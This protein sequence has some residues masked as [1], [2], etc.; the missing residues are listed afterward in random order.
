MFWYTPAL[1]LL[2][3]VILLRS[4]TNKC[5]VSVVQNDEWREEMEERKR[6]KWSGMEE[7]N[8]CVCIYSEHTHIHIRV[9]GENDRENGRMYASM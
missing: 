4:K 3:V 5:N 7:E 8:E 6:G 1:V 9:G 2:L